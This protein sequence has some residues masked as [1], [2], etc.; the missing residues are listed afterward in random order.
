MSKLQVGQS[1]DLAEEQDCVFDGC[2]ASA[3]LNQQTVQSE[4]LPAE[5]AAGL[6]NFMTVLIDSKVV[7]QFLD[8]S[9]TE[10][11]ASLKSRNN[12]RRSQ[13][14]PR[15]W[16]LLTGRA[17]GDTMRVERIHPA[18]NVREIDE[19]VLKEFDEV[20]VPCFG[21]PYARK[22]RGFWCSSAELLRIT[23]EAEAEG[24]EMLGSIHMH[25]D[26]HHIGPAHERGQRIDQRPTK[27]DEYLFR[28][29]GWPLNIICYL[30]SRETEI[31]HTFAAW[32]PPDF[33]NPDARA[34]E[35]AI[36]FTLAKIDEGDT[37]TW[38]NLCD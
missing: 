36:R 3:Q 7:S 37:I 14:L 22:G 16:G 8:N 21:A 20:I 23:R 9:V 15:S 30:E 11:K 12:G 24:L 25:P 1:T 28:N 35:L 19:H 31:V 6:S 18:R 26:W 29:T 33:D 13:H 17:H 27:M 2:T 34:V 4:L 38:H 10:Y 32:A 5:D